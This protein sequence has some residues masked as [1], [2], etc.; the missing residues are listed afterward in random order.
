VSLKWVTPL[1]PVAPQ[2][3]GAYSLIDGESCTALRPWDPRRGK[4]KDTMK[5]SRSGILSFITAGALTTV[6]GVSFAASGP[7]IPPGPSI[8][9]CPT[10]EQIEAHLEEYGFDY[11]PTVPCGENG[12]ELTGRE[13]SAESE[14]SVSMDQSREDLRQ[15]LLTAR[16]A[17]DED[18][19]PLTMEI[20]LED[21]SEAT[22]H[23]FGDASLFE[24][25]TPA[26]L[27]RGYLR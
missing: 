6:V 26:E 18:G 21:G 9:F 1:G 4:G 7:D 24:D 20:V 17:P 3:N 16:L 25:V 2:K 13:S 23:I 14:S 15:A 12:E 5:L 10:I 22:V 8:D 11:K 27:A 19:D